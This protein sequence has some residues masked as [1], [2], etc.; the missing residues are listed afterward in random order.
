M[1]DAVT[2]EQALGRLSG[3]GEDY[4]LLEGTVFGRPC[5]LFKNGP[6]TCEVGTYLLH[7]MRKRNIIDMRFFGEK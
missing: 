7:N 1:T 3:E 5:R 6:K 2:R 4:E